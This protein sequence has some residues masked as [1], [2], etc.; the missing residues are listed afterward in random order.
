M[1]GSGVH[2]APA[3]RES[4]PPA[5]DPVS[6]QI[7]AKALAAAVATVV[8]APFGPG[9]AAVSAVVATFVADGVREVA[10]RRK[11]GHRR[12]VG[13]T[14]LVL[15]F[16]RVDTAFA[17]IIGAGDEPQGRPPARVRR[18]RVG[19]ALL[20]STAAVGLVVVGFTGVEAAMGRSSITDRP[21]FFGG[22]SSRLPTNTEPPTISGDA[23]VGATLQG[24]AG[25]WK[26]DPAPTLS[27]Q[28]LR[29][30]SSGACVPI[31]GKTGPTYDLRKDDLGATIV[32]RVTARNSQ[33]TERASSRP[34]PVIVLP[35]VPPAAVG[36]PKLTWSG[37]T[38]TTTAGQWTGNSI[39]FT[40]QWQLCSPDGKNCDD[41]KGETTSAYT[42]FE[43]LP[44]GVRSVVTATNA[45]G[46][47]SNSSQPYHCEP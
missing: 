2:A 20:T 12:L 18:G 11:W 6:L 5:E 47:S 41:L 24:T 30:A 33:G 27:Y 45:V 28:W 23:F 21:F 43:G 37:I 32:L 13:L 22:T 40:Y 39:T 10:K 17:T 3:A 14:A 26:G 15:I 9:A 19:H 34:S 8:T 38:L 44:C 25:D 16:N 36:A 7:L 29:C 42:P 1:A 31:A 35:L 46:S 4:S